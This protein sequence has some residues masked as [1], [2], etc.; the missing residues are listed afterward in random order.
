MDSFHYNRIIEAVDAQT[1][2]VRAIREL[3]IRIITWS[4]ASAVIVTFLAA[5]RT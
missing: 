4:V 1:R 5:N 2:E 3:I